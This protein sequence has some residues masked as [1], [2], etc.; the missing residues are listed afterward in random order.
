MF[1][2]VCKYSNV[3]PSTQPWF[4]PHEPAIKQ[5]SEDTLTSAMRNDLSQCCNDATY[6]SNCIKVSSILCFTFVLK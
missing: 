4:V 2:E 5:V 3:L 6:L 1:I